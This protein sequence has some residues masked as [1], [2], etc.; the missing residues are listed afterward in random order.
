MESGAIALVQDQSRVT[1]C[2]LADRVDALAAALAD[3]GVGRGDRVAYLGLNDIATFETLFAAVHVGAIFVPLNTRLA[4]CE[5]AYMLDDSK[6]TVFVVGPEVEQTGLDA[7][8][9]TRG[10][11]TCKLLRLRAEDGA[12]PYEDAI[13]EHTGHRAPAVSVGL[14]DPALI[15]YTSGTTGRPKGAVLTHGNIIW[16]TVSQ[17]AHLGIGRDDITLCSAPLFH[18]LGLGQITL[19]TLYVG[20]TIIVIPRFDAREFLA[21]IARMKATAFPL[22]PTMLQM[23]CEI[24]EWEVADVTSVRCVVV[25]GSPVPERV[26]TIWMQ[27]GVQVLQGYGMTE[28][29]PGVVMALPYGAKEHQASAGVPHFFTDVALLTTA[30]DIIAGPGQGELLVRGPNIFRGYWGLPEATEQAFVDGWFRTGDV[31]RIDDDGWT[32]I[33]GR[34]KDLIISGGE[35]IY[36]AEVEA[37]ITQHGDI[38]DCAVVAVPD[39]QWGEVG[40][41]FVVARRGHSLDEQIIRGYL[42]TK[43]A[44][45][46]IPKYYVFRDDLPHNAIGKIQRFQLRHDALEYLQLRSRCAEGVVGQALCEPSLTNGEAGHLGDVVLG[47]DTLTIDTVARTARA[48]QPVSVR[49]DVDAA[50]RMSDSVQVRD[51]LLA[52]NRPI[53][54]VTTGFGDSGQFH[55]GQHKAAQLQRNMV[56][57]HL[58]GTG[59]VA[60]VDVARASMLIRANCLARG[61]SG[62]RREVVD[63]LLSCLREN[64]TPLIPE[65]GSVGASGDLVPLCYLADML[66]GG[67]DVMVD[68]AR[69]PA[70]TALARRGLK[71]VTLEAKEGLAL[72]NGTSFMCAF[73]VLAVHDAGQ[74]AAVSDLCTALTAEA[75]Q[76]NRGHFDPL[77]H[78][79]KPHPGQAGSA[80]R[81]RSL[82]AGSELCVNHPQVLNANPDITEQGVVMLDRIVQDRYSVRCAPYVTGVLID[83]MQWASRWLEIEINSTND[84]PLFDPVSRDVYSG[85]NFY[86][87]HVGLAMDSLKTAV[88]S[89]GDLLDRQVALLVDN[90]FNHG[91]PLNLTPPVDPRAPTAGLCHGFKGMQLACSAL[92]GE[93][94]KL[95]MP[96]TAF[97]RST[98]AHNQDKV[99][100]GTI[101][102]RDA[103]TTIELVTEIAA[104]N[105]LTACQAAHLRGAELLG[106]GTAACYALIRSTVP[107]LDNDRRQDGD[108]AAVVELIRSGVL[109]EAIAEHSPRAT[110]GV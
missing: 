31:V 68:G 51:T 91:L 13:K 90:K 106:T 36:P 42:E 84:N 95:T 96:A 14:D 81:I 20:G 107:Q 1:Y 23:L 48:A 56:S 16:N 83:T 79:H 110:E 88:A 4:A 17:F 89:L 46:K 58:N 43:L 99:S 86:G 59:P 57:Y 33:V 108:V 101:A 103:R 29:A 50:R 82:L 12:S 60:A 97:S 24:P 70:M 40:L 21:T 49:V 22:A 35:N 10:P 93:A 98:E 63:M 78:Q 69:L 9:Q 6:P 25:G 7:I 94:L 3:F 72:I 37:V 85:G 45:Y 104:I 15:F 80:A 71:P 92:A 67:G 52:A 76:G 77:I 64:I 30:G 34:V 8:A 54:G 26:T 74:L 55:I 53:Y 75:L 32:Y 100:M 38:E 11:G 105:L 61:Y 109:G 5:I 102:A 2:D 41:A 44:G 18:V 66:I 39:E 62:I 19:P 28:A 87:G 27:R 47:N 73:A 65:R